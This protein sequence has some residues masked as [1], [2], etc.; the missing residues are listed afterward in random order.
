MFFL[1]YF[2]QKDL[3]EDIYFGFASG[4]DSFISGVFCY[5]GRTGLSSG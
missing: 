5:L 3:R 1:F 2:A 4:S